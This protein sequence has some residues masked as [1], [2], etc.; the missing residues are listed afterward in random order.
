MLAKIKKAALVIFITCLIW[1][2]ADLSLDK[3]L[4][5]QSM[6]IVASKADPKRWITIEGKPEAIIKVDLRG[7]VVK[8]NDL[9]KKIQAGDEK[10]DVVFDPVK[11][12]MAT[13]GDYSLTDVRKFLT[14]SD[15]IRDYGLQVKFAKPDKLQNIKVVALA[16]KTLPIKCVDEADNEIP[17]AKMM[18]DI[19]T[20]YAPDTVTEAKVKLASIAERKQARGAP[21]TKNP[22]IELTKTEVRFS[23]ANI[24]IELPAVSEDMKPYA[25][26]G[27]LG[28]IFSA[29]LAGRYEVE[30]IKRPEVGSITILA[31]PEARDAY[32]LTQFEVLLSIQDDDIGK[33]EVTRQLIYNFPV[34]YVRDD[35]IRLKGEPAEAKFKLVPVAADVNQPTLIFN[36]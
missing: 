8:I 20:I 22:Y 28:F 9:N 34:Q 12:N 36:P 3:D 10:M 19:I 26:N 16:E 13:P 33:P 14:E 25:I 11:E 6:T 32:E 24:K 23:D 15:K 35:K 5:D 31:T 21:V 2:W 30:F 7:P 1:V 17:G 27:T 4:T 18:P 29:N